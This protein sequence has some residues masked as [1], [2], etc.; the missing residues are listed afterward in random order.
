MDLE[1]LVALRFREVERPQAS[2]HFSIS[3]TTVVAATVHGRMLRP[4][5]SIWRRLRV[6]AHRQAKTAGAE[7]GRNRLPVQLHV[8]PPYE[9]N[10]GRSVG[11]KAIKQR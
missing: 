9:L 8:H 5:R 6:R 4:M 2:P 3:T 11:A 1:D 7:G 10:H